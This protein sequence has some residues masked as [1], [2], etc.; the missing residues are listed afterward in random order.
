LGM[1]SIFGG[2]GVVLIEVGRL[3]YTHS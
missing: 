2:I 3:F 1:D